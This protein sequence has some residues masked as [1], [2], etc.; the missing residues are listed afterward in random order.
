MC[1]PIFTLQQESSVYLITTGIEIK[2]NSNWT[3]Y[4]KV[5]GNEKKPY[6][7]SAKSL[8]LFI[9]P[10]NELFTKKISLIVFFEI[11]IN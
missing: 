7:M 11:F 5:T 6:L 9:K 4:E 10:K 8:R 3:S 1:L 2:K